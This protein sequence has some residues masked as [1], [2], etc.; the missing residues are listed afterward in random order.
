VRTAWP[1]AEADDLTVSAQRIAARVAAATTRYPGGQAGL[2]CEAG[3]PRKLEGWKAAWKRKACERK[4]CEPSMHLLSPAA[5][6]SDRSNA[7]VRDH[8]AL[9]GTA[10][11]R[12][13]HDADRPRN[14]D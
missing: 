10:G 11:R 13:L 5:P 9:D 8:R 6:G 4:A 2:A 7:W 3:E 12:E 14:P 1:I